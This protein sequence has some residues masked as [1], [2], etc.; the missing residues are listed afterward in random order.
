MYCNIFYSIVRE[1]IKRDGTIINDEDADSNTAL[2][3]AAT[4]GHHRVIDALLERGAIIDA[5]LMTCNIL[6][7]LCYKKCFVQ[8]LQ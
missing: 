7:F 8:D 2:H 1:L 4:N 3:L 6:G 5:R